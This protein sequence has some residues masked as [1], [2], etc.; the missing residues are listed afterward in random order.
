VR[1]CGIRA[2]LSQLTVRFATSQVFLSVDGS[3]MLTAKPHMSSD[4]AVAWEALRAV[5]ERDGKIN[6]QHFSAI[7]NLGQGDVGTVRL[8]EMKGSR[9]GKGKSG[10]CVFAVKTLNKLE[11]IE[12]NKVPPPLHPYLSLSVNPNCTALSRTTSRFVKW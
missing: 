5:Y 4:R 6:A 11:M 7:K 1:K 2:S 12:R 8:V 3:K 10:R 9:G